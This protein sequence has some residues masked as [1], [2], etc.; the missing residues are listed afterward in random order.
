[1]PEAGPYNRMVVNEDNA[2]HDGGAFEMAH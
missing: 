2:K 1:L